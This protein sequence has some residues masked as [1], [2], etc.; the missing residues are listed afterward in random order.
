MTRIKLRAPAAPAATVPDLA[1][2]ITLSAE[3][4][5][6]VADVH[7]RWQLTPPVAAMLQ[8]VAEAL[9]KRAICD[10]ITAREGVSV[11]DAKGASKAHPAAMLGVKYSDA[12]AA[13]LQRILTNLG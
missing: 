6:L 4:E 5:K 11:R 3:A 10:A 7:A 1:A 9:T 12:A 13:G 8:L 2:P